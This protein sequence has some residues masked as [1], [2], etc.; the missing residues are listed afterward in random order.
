MTQPIRNKRI[1]VSIPLE[2]IDKVSA[3]E[4]SIRRG[5]PSTLHR[6]QARRP[7]APCRA[8]LFARLVDDPSA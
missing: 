3:Q 2:A 8:M 4:K 5:H 1:E 7:L 6:W